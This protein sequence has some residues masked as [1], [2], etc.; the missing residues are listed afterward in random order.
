MF[1]L[2]T[3]LP[4]PLNSRQPK[5]LHGPAMG[6]LYRIGSLVNEGV[7]PSIAFCA[8]IEPHARRFTLPAEK[9]FCASANVLA[10]SW[11]NR[12]ANRCKVVLRRVVLYIHTLVF[13]TTQIGF[14]SLLLPAISLFSLAQHQLYLGAVLAQPSPAR[15]TS[16][17]HCPAMLPTQPAT[18]EAVIER[19]SI[20]RGKEALTLPPCASS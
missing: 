12:T 7:M 10:A 13:N 5:L 19:G 9:I 1:G 16:P 17:T 2:C 20:H 18:R 6:A 14:Q 15:Y 8:V 11:F 4:Q 3:Y